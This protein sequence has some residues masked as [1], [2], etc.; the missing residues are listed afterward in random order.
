MT[1]SEN[2]I[3]ETLMVPLQTATS[4]LQPLTMSRFLWQD[5]K[6]MLVKALAEVLQ[7]SV[8]LRFLGG[9]SRFLSFT[10]D[11]IIVICIFVFFVFF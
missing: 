10:E 11:L 4:V 6:T 5:Y 9:G 8:K 1:P 7:S 3:S 2:E